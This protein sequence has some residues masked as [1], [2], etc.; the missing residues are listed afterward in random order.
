MGG[1]TFFTPALAAQQPGPDQ[2]PDQQQSLQQ[3]IT[4]LKSQ[5]ASLQAA[6]K[7]KSKAAPSQKGMPAKSKMSSG[8][9]DDDS[10]EMGSM[11]SSSGMKSPSSAPM[12]DDMDDSMGGGA[13]ASMGKDK[14]MASSGCCGMGSMGKPMKSDSSSNMSAPAMS[15][16]KNGSMSA[17]AGSSAPSLLHLGSKDFFLDHA[18]HLGLSN[19][20]KGSLQKIKQAAVEQKSSSQSQIDS[21]ESELWKLTSANS[22]DTAAIDKR[23]DEI[24]MLRA[25]QQAD[26]IHSVASAV[27]LLTAGQQAVLLKTGGR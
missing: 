3:Q 20:Q 7:S 17:M 23:V 21:A 14:P 5:V 12:K 11:P 2:S 24:A 4:E 26:Y 10:M 16:M 22:P 18:S 8:M 9:E 27:K 19:E 25:H 15:G 13:K 1:L 6:L